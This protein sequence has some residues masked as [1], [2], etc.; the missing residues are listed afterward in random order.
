M[1]LLFSIFIGNLDL[2]NIQRGK[3]FATFSK[4]IHFHRKVLK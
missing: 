1:T 2:Q 4:K 3:T